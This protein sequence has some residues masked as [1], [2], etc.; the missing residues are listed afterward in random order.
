MASHEASDLTPMNW[1]GMTYVRR[2]THHRLQAIIPAWRADLAVQSP[3]MSQPRLPAHTETTSF[4]SRGLTASLQST[5]DV[6]AVFKTLVPR[7]I[8]WSAF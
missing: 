2:R 1:V 6:A 7:Q 3:E 8:D 5:D 4:Q